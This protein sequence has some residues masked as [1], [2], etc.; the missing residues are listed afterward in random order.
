M[1]FHLFSGLLRQATAQGSR[2]TVLRPLQWF[3]GICIVGLLGCLKYGAPLGVLILFVVMVALIFLLFMGAYIY[4]LCTD[5][6]AL[7]SETYSIQKLAIERGL[8]GDSTVGIFEIEETLGGHLIK[9]PSTITA[10]GEKK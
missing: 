5:K 10:L 2:S 4:C 9:Q 3:V 8:V 1:P 7:R 6:D